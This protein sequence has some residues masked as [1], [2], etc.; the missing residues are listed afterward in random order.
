LEEDEE[1]EAAESRSSIGIMATFALS[2]AAAKEEDET[3]ELAW[4]NSVT[5]VSA[6][7]SCSCELTV[8]VVSEAG[9]FNSAPSS[10]RD[11]SW[12]GGRCH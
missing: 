6:K 9:L 1:V 11:I 2:D 7:L 8:V 12:V 3:V 4:V 5:V 10:A